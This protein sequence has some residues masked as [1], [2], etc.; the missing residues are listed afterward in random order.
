MSELEPLIACP[1]SPDNVTP[2]RE[3][4][5]RQNYQDPRSLPVAYPQLTELERVKINTAML[6]PPPCESTP[7]TLVKGPNIHDLPNV[8]LECCWISELFP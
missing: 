8:D 7:V 1:S 5:G 2:V 4:A 6:V 3:V